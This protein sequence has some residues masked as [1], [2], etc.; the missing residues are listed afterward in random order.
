MKIYSGVMGKVTSHAAGRINRR[1]I[2][3][4]HVLNSGRIYKQQNGITYIRSRR[5]EILVV[6]STGN[7]KTATI[8]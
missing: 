2:P 8:R 1:N 6:T 5:Y 3:V 4:K 7:I